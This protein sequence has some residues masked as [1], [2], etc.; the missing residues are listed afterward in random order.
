MVGRFLL[1]KET[2]RIYRISNYCFEVPA[3][4]GKEVPPEELYLEMKQVAGPLAPG[5]KNRMDYFWIFA[6]DINFND[7]DLLP[8]SA[9]VLYGEKETRNVR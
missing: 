1:E 6:S 9:E 3:F 5:F 2:K 7:Y 8:E 4:V